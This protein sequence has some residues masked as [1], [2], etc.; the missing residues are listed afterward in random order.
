M[1][2]ER[3]EAARFVGQRVPRKEDRRLLTGKGSY[4]D[5]IVVPGMLYAT[6]VRSQVARGAIRS[7]DLEAARAVPGVR[8]V[9]GPDELAQIPVDIF[10][11]YGLP[12]EPAP[13][14]RPLA[15]GRVTHVGEPLA[16]VVADTRYIAEDAAG[17]VF[18]DIDYED[19]VVTMAQAANGPPVHEGLA[20]N[21]SAQAATPD[22]PE[23]DRIIAGAAHVVTGT[24][25]HQRQVHTPMETRG[26]VVQKQG[27]GELSI[28]QACQSPHMA[29]RYYSIAFGLPD[30]H[31]RVIAK[32]VGG[33]FGLK[34]QPGREE[35]AVVAAGLLLGRPIKWIE[36]RIENL[37]AGYQAREQEMRIKM[38]FD[39]DAR[40]LAAQ[41]EYDCNVGAF[42]A[43]AD[44]N[45]LGMMMFP[46]PYKLPRYGFKAKGWYSNTCG[47]APYRGPWMIE[48]LARETMLDKAARQIGIDPVEI[49]LRNLISKEDQPFSMPTGPVIDRT[50]PRETLQAALD[51]IGYKAFRAEQAAA[52]AAGRYLGIGLAVYVEPTTM[53]MFGVLSSDVANI[54]VETNG[55]ITA[56]ISTHSQGHGT[57]TTMAQVVADEL[58]V[59]I[60]DVTV[61]EDDSSRGGFGP[62]AGGSRQA[63]SGGGAAI[64]ATKIVKQKIM[65]IAGH[66]L[67]ANPDHIQI[68]RGVITVEGVPDVSTTIA[69]VAEAAYL[70]PD[71]LP[72][73]MEMGLEGNYR[74]RPPPIVFSNATHACI[75]EV[76]GDTGMVKILRWVSSEDCGVMINPAVVEGQIA[77]GVVQ[78]IGGVLLE[79]ASY[80]AQGNPTAATFKDYLI[81][82]ALDVPRI[83]FAH[84]TTPSTTEGGFKG[85]GEGGAIIAPPTMVNAVA[86]AMV[87]FGRECLDLPLTPSK[88]LAAIVAVGK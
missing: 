27:S 60:E 69:R 83:E 43:G 87:P 3:P 37:T 79:H 33:A 63:V 48:S 11:L 54:R 45:S 77:G 36:D 2:A 29:A 81:P 85:V 8:A 57:A 30:H 40:L 56:T 61:L 34:V 14:Q 52:R 25:T 44:C 7:L 18:A 49:R 15:V 10:A 71:R 58:G 84:I 16:V 78:G 5:D 12:N 35:I 75:C 51:K 21:L 23:L 41:V 73:E 65:T 82:S 88:L 50:T 62:G 53:A 86:D 67:N 19:P 70:D 9:Y 39:A 6:F 80:D 31:V 13:V 68:K 1:I 20:S 72:P 32:D 59:D 28:W 26:L 24:I 66:L 17:L 46:G 22:D 64:R 42:P 74:Y 55:K 47:Q 76:D 4:V 38:A